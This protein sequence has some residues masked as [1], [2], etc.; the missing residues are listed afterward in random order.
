MVDA[1][2]IVAFTGPGSTDPDTGVWSRPSE[3]LY[4]G[5]CRVQSGDALPLTPDYGGAEVTVDAA[6]VSIPIAAPDVAVGATVTI[7][8][9]VYDPHLEGA[10]F[11]VSSVLRKSHATARRLRCEVVTDDA[12]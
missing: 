9:S 12:G 6:T 2:E 8:A 11:T 10:V 3:S 5:M 7:T 4:A 1:C